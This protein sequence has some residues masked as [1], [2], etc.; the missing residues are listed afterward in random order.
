[1]P[2]IPVHIVHQLSE[3]NVEEVARALGIMVSRHQAFCFMHD[4]KCPSLKF[5]RDG[6]LWKCFS[7]NK[8]GNA[9]ELVRQYYNIEFVD[10][11]KWLCRQ[12]GIFLEN[13]NAPQRFV[14]RNV[15]LR[16]KLET[17]EPPFNVEIGEWLIE[18]A[19]LSEV[20]KTFLYT[21]RKLSPDVISRL[22]IRSVSD[23]RKLL[24][25]MRSCFSE[26]ELLRA[27]VFYDIVKGY[28]AFE[29]P[30]ILIPYHSQDGQLI[31]MQ[32]RSLRK[33]PKT[34]YQFFR[35][36]KPTLYNLPVTNYIAKGEKLYISEGMTDC[37]AMLSAGLNAVALPSA[38]NLPLNEFAGLTDYDLVM[39]AD[40]DFAGLK[41]YNELKYYV[42]AMGGTLSML[43]LPIGFKDYGEYYAATH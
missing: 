43:K 1:M 5:K 19:G 41:A 14:P 13:N 3:L 42:T 31:G 16:Q 17:V 34:R 23:A 9:I 12:Y 38:S 27:G 40:K 33:Y 32:S 30:C 29:I 2:Y 24:D 25:A 36:F 39:C 18:N 22:K 4:E 7:C 26:E 20:A 28:P 10:A 21:E 11:C 8:G 37:F 6:R 15:M 35:G